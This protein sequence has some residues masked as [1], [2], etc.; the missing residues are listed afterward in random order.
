MRKLNNQL[1]FSPSDL[2]TFSDSKFDSWMERCFL[3]F[4]D[5]VQ[6][7][8][9]DESLEIVARHGNT[10]E[11][12]FLSLLK[13]EGYDIAEIDPRS[14]S[15]E[16]D[17][18]AAMRNGR[19][20]VYQGLLKAGE[21]AGLSDF[22]VKVPGPS[23][24]GDFHYEV[25]DTKLSKKAKPYYLL[26]LCCYA[27][28]LETIQGRL[29]GSVRVVL[30]DLSKKEFRTLEYLYR[31]RQLKAEFLEFQGRFSKDN[32]PEDWTAGT[33][34]RWNAVSEKLLEGC[35]HLSRVANIRQSQI[36]RLRDAD[37]QT[38][39]ALSESTAR[40]IP[41]MTATT[42]S[43]LKQQARLQIRSKNENKTV[44]ELLPPVPGQGLA[45]LPPTSVND[46]YFDMEGY[47][48]TEGGL[49]Y[50]FGVVYEDSDTQLVFK[51]WW[52]HSRE[53]EKVAFEQ[54][55]DWIYAR[56]MAD[57][58]MHVYHYAAYE[59]SAVKRLA[60][61]HATRVE[62]I[63]NMLR[64]EVFVDLFQVVRQSLC[65]GEPSYSIK[66]VEH[67]Y[68]EKRSGTVSK[69]TDSVVFYENWLMAPD[70]E[71]WEVSKI[72]KEIRDYNEEDC[73]STIQLAQWLRLRQAENG[74]VFSGKVAEAPTI[75]REQ[76]AAAVL[77][78]KLCEEAEAIT[79]P[80]IKRVQ[81]LL[82]G[83]L[84]FHKREDKP[85]WSR[86]FE[87]QKMSQEEL[88]HDLDCLAGLTWTR[89]PA[90]Q[91][92]KSF[93]YQYKFDPNQDTKL[94][95]GKP[96][97][98]VHDQSSTKIAELDR[99]NGL[100]T[101]VVGP[102]KP[103]PPDEIALMADEFVDSS[104]ISESIYRVCQNWH[105]KRVMPQAL[106]DLL[107]R[108]EPQIRGRFAGSSIANAQ[109]IR[110]VAG[111]I[112]R[113]QNTCLSIQ[114]PPGTGKTYTASHSIIELLRQGK[115]VGITSNSHKAIDNLLAK[116]AELG[117]S[118]GV[119]VCAAKVGPND[120]SST[121]R[122]M[123]GVKQIRGSNSFFT[124]GALDSFN[125]IAGTAWLFSNENA[126]G[127]LDYLFVD[128]AGQ[129]SLANL[130]A[131]SPSTSNIVLLGDQMQLEQP[132]QGSHPGECGQSC[133]EYLL[134]ERATI[135]DNLG[136]FLGTTR[137]MHSDICEV[138]SQ[139]VYD[140][141]LTS[142]DDNNKQ[143]LIAPGQL[144][145]AFSKR[146]GI[147]WIPVSH[148]G[149]T[150]ASDEEVLAIENLV[151]LL[152]K[153]CVSDKQ[154][155]INVVALSDILIVTPYN[156]QVRKIA[157]RIPGACVASVDKFQG[158]EAPI[159][160]LSMCASEGSG[161]PRGLDFL[162]SRS[163]LNVAIS[164]AKTLAFVVGSPEL[165]NTRTTS[166]KQM[167]LL[168]FFCQI[169]SA[170]QT[171]NDVMLPDEAILPISA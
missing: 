1:I 117:E 156:M 58:G 16:R 101:I 91:I 23:D 137:R 26:Q 163:R 95:A 20:V 127:L 12:A 65:V 164:R 17:T 3:E 30:G 63:D 153:C 87:R 73:V 97:R 103:A 70:G 77:A 88:C 142:H 45:L 166:L 92:K 78:R 89:R 150:Q 130:T 123:P 136:I 34:S 53:E 119:S 47:P 8:E 112:S 85:M 71:T 36:D 72:L 144:S 37:I 14:E 9:R 165:V 76:T 108:N 129:V 68:R 96:C 44:W 105:E 61:R 51:D 25:W 159:V 168:S 86:M 93:G 52:A 35:D 152:L 104:P 120:S 31:Y 83:L 146:S 38:M 154:G 81:K 21:F 155:N 75:V 48:L 84:E 158:Q 171:A 22:L 113:M 109:D 126:A 10:H 110:D 102:S 50:L 118:E 69:A 98:F 32:P 147:V 40:S 131:V 15:A 149:N 94:E 107:F 140:S 62:E 64:S 145:T 157:S 29:P 90:E 121:P 28:M 7:D 161:S 49:E 60:G 41:K 106:S 124:N 115:R 66:Y 39:T 160:I 100:V 151:N 11:L 114:G 6:P 80:E 57:P 82:A 133:L 59:V 33:Y 4:P 79:D 43:K 27:E 128:E 125:L 141:R 111:A 162:F 18:I 143:M 54:F 122:R 67:L 5:E 134:Q 13:M 24:L 46:V 148:S 74:I 138:I 167:K 170:G 132:I 169:V 19:E 56:W 42:F 135:P 2:I 55:V 99:I 116:V 139:A